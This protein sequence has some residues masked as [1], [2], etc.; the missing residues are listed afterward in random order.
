MTRQR[1]TIVSSNYTSVVAAWPGSAAE[2]KQ[3]LL[4]RRVIAEV[5]AEDS[6]AAMRIW[7]RSLGDNQPS[8]LLEPC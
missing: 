6:D 4:N 1:F 5:T 8:C 3:Y 2:N 7:R